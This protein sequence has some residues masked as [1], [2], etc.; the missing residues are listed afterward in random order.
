MQGRVPVLG[1]TQERDPSPKPDPPAPRQHSAG[2]FK[3]H[4]GASLGWGFPPKPQNPG[5]DL[6]GQF[7]LF[8]QNGT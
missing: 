2:C 8:S 7:S 1:G 3:A 4:P 6:S 5:S